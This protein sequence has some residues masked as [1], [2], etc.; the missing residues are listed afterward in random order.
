MQIKKTLRC[1]LKPIRMAKI[2]ISESS[3]CSQGCGEK[4]HSSI[5][6]QIETGTTTVEINL[7]ILQKIGNRST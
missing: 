4:K 7:E 2:K 6:G 3:T 5:V 1:H